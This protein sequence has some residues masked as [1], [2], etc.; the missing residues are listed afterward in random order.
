MQEYMLKINEF[1]KSTSDIISSIVAQEDPGGFHIKP[2]K[3][4][5]AKQRH[6]ANKNAR[7]SR[8]KNRR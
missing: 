7:K 8:K 2:H 4:S 3:A 1:A 6:A 5:R